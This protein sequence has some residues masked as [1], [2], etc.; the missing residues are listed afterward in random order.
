MREG[1]NLRPRIT[2]APVE[3]HSRVNGN[4]WNGNLKVMP[5]AELMDGDHYAAIFVDFAAAPSEHLNID[6][7]IATLSDQGIY[8]LQQRII[9]HLTRFEVDLASLAEET[10][11]V[12]WEMHQQRDWLETVYDDESDWTT[13][14]LIAEDAA[15]DAWLREG[16]PSRRTKLKDDHTHT[17]L[18][19]EARKAA[20]ARRDE[21]TQ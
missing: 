8:V 1:T 3:R 19:R 2:V 15:F 16:N 14:N 5:L 4:G 18:R 21:V 7:R 6:A 9:K 13:T 10:A 20:L 11:P 12:L 17:D